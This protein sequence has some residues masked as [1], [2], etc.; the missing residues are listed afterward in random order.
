LEHVRP[1]RLDRIDDGDPGL[2]RFERRDDLLELD[3]GEQLDASAA[4][5]RRRARIATCS[6]DSSPLT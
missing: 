5:E 4:S 3:F 2:A 1:Q 6:A